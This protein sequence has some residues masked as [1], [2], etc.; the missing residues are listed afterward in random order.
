MPL[1]RP[2]EYS[3]DPL[4]PAGRVSGNGVCIEERFWQDTAPCMEPVVVEGC[5][6]GPALER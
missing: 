1:N 2:K 3:Y 4:L 6:F 5:D